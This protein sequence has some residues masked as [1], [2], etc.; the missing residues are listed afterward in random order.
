[1]SAVVLPQ[2]LVQAAAADAANSP[3][4]MF[5]DDFNAGTMTNWSTVKGTWTNAGTAAQGVSTGDGLTLRQGITGADFTYEADLKLVTAKSAGHLYFRSNSSGSNTY[6]VTLDS[7]GTTNV[8]K[9]LKFTNS[10]YAPIQSV[11]QSL[12]M[13]QTYHVKVV[14]S[15]SNIKIYFNDAATPII[16]VN[17]TSFTSGQFGLGTYGGTVQF[18]NVVAYD[19]TLLQRE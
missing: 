14:T 7:T 9:L 13:G 19:N 18:D 4:A 6:A 2:G 17:D 11:N 5:S 12:T 8:V 3:S 16:D 10:V 1:M 15:G